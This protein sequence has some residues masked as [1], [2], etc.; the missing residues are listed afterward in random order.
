MTIDIEYSIDSETGMYALHEGLRDIG[1]ETELPWLV[2]QM[3][4][5]S[6]MRSS[7]GS[8][9]GLMELNRRESG[10]TWSS[11][12]MPSCVSWMRPKHTSAP[13]ERGRS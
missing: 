7:T 8:L 4:A 13:S 12:R 5:L 11:A 2:A 3:E 6:A 10:D 1:Q 9:P